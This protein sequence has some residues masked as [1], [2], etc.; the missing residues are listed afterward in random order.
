ME[1]FLIKAL[2]LIAALSLLVIIHEFGHFLWARVFKIRVEKFYLFFNPWFT[3]FKWKPKKSD[4]EYG[5]GWLPLG[6]YVKIAGMVD[7][8]MD[9][10][11]MAQP[12]KPDEFRVKPAW[13]RLLVMTGGVLNNFILAIIIYAGIAWYWGEKTIPYQ[14]A[15][16]GM[17]FAPAAI[18]LGFRNGD[19]LLSADG[20]EINQKDRGHLF[21]LLESKT[22]TVLRNHR[23]TIDILLPKNAIEQLDAEQGFMGY[24]IPVFVNKVVPGEPAAK[25]GLQPDD[26]IIAVG[27]SLTPSFGELSR[28]LYLN[29]GRNTTVTLLRGNDTISVAVTPTADGKLGFELK[30][31]LEIFECDT[32]RYGFLESIP[33]GVTNGTEMLVTYVGSLK[34]IFSKKGAESIGG[35]GAIGNMFPAKWNWLTFW[36]MTAFLSII[37]A[38]MNLL[39]IPALDGGHVA[40]LLWEVITRR[41][42]SDKF[43]EKAQMAGMLFL[44][45]LLLY[46][47]FND[48]YRFFIK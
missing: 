16:E 42:P 33:V 1:S 34:H 23:D 29:G 22:V 41:K 32:T 47:N 13:Q 36:E 3:L 9:K 30:K 15:Y 4:T 43:L 12:P 19:I 6:G 18:E 37:L 21:K 31:P 25:A 17:D 28:A 40:F 48:I 39:P 45:A 10:E 44:I 46:A 14:H 27:D 2:Q 20:R 8:S 24:R 11:Q 5:I 7:E 38:F 35:F 26:R